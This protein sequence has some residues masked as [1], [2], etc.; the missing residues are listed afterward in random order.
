M[1]LTTGDAALVRVSAALAAAGASADDP[2]LDAALARAETEADAGHV[3]EVILQSY[4]FL[5]YPATLNAFARWREMSGR[6]PPDPSGA[7]WAGWVARGKE[8]CRTVYGGQYEGLR[9]NVRRL[10]PDMEQW[11][12]AEGYGKVLG[13][14]GPDLPTRELCIVAVLAVA[15][16]PT[17][18][19]SHLRGALNAGATEAAV[20]EALDIALDRVDPEAEIIARQVWARVR[21]RSR[22]ADSE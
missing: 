12:V 4:L 13:R 1:T 14:P 17:Q 10:H 3:E 11:M 6:A 21:E 19:Y 2:A 22:E 18:L 8:V 9:A 7:D 20:A 5:G 16:A 15:R